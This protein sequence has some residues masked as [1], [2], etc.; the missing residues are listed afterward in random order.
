MNTMIMITQQ[1]VLT[2][3]RNDVWRRIKI[4]IWTS[5][6]KP[7][8]TTFIGRFVQKYSKN[9]HRKFG[10]SDIRVSKKAELFLF[11]FLF[12]F[13]LSQFRIFEGKK[14]IKTMLVAGRR[15]KIYID[16]EM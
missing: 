5:V 7:A 15:N 10:F 2:L 16:T 9:S 3:F 14:A 6:T 8:S 12:V 11:C 4:M 1:F 13:L